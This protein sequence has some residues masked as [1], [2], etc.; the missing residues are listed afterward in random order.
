[1]FLAD[2][3][4]TNPPF[5]QRPSAPLERVNIIINASEVK[6]NVRLSDNR[7]NENV[8]KLL[9]VAE[10]SAPREPET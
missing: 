6:T 5:A 7:C 10:S 3:C 8:M 4:S 2:V 9:I 1:M